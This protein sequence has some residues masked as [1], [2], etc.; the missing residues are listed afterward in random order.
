MILVQLLL[1]F[2]LGYVCGLLIGPLLGGYYSKPGDISIRGGIAGGLGSAGSFVL[3]NSVWTR[4]WLSPLARHTIWTSIVV[5]ICSI[6][7]VEW[8]GP[9]PRAEDDAIDPAIIWRSSVRKSRVWLWLCL[10]AIVYSIWTRF[11]GPPNLDGRPRYLIGLLAFVGSVTF[12]V[13]TAVSGIRR[14]LK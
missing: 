12:L 13:S 6:A 11:I 4:E 8:F 2:F 14:S 1:R 7:I 3:L 9:R 5:G 10:P